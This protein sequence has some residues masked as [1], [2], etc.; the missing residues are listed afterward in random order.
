MW[1]SHVVAV[2]AFVALGVS[3]AAA[4][5][6]P[7]QRPAHAGKPVAPIELVAAAERSGDAWRVVVG[8]TPTSDVSALEVEVDGRVQRF[9]A[10]S[11][12]VPR[13]V[14]VPIAVA[15]GTGQDVV[16]VVRAGGRSVAKIVRVGAPK[17]AEAPK[18]VRIRII[19]GREIAEVRS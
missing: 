19:H 10:T 16:V 1:K 7:V 8:A 3:A 5:R 18:P 17:P 15:V 12:K 11:A 4:E 14:M 6:P 2:L 13:R 9:G